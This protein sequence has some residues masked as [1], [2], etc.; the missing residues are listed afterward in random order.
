M[1]FASDNTSGVPD[2]ILDAL[3]AAN[4]GYAMGYGADTYMDALRGR[5]RAL[6]EAPEAEVFLVSTGSAANAMACAS[7]CPP[8]GA[9]YCHRLAH[10]EVDEC[11]APEF[12]TG[13]A[14]LT[15]VAGENGKIDPDALALTLA[16]SCKGVVHHVQPGLLSLT[17]LT[18]CGTRYSVAEIAALAEIAHAH[19]LPVHLDGARFANALVAEGCSPADMTWRAGVDVLCLGGTKN[20]L[21]GVEAV[22]FFNTAQAWEFQ[23]RRKRGGHLPSKHR[24]LSA[25]MLAWLEGDLWLNLA[26]NANAMAARLEAGLTEHAQIA[27]PRGGNMLFATWPRAGHDRLQAVGAQYYL[28][29]DYATFD[30]P[31]PIGARLVTSWST[32]ESDVDHFLTALTGQNALA[33]DRALG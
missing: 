21:F 14:K 31:D 16:Q 24:Y 28:W 3:R 8:W 15:H 20:G 10:I 13:G 7:L 6:F 5:I 19:G 26:R 32:T 18:E 12:F 30:D 9:I 1:Q 4:Q 22:I 27:Y 29:P 17:N 25:Q 2:A 33:S 11:G 23:L